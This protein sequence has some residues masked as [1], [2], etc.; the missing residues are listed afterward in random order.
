VWAQFKIRT[1]LRQGEIDFI[2][3]KN[4]AICASF[5]PF[6]YFI[7]DVFSILN[8]SSTI[9]NIPYNNKELIELGKRK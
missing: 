5:S 4:I 1:Q 8:N 7:L 6:K 2:W 9:Y 3:M